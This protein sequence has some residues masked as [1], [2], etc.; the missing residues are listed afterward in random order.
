MEVG[1]AIGN[2]NG[3]GVLGGCYDGSVTLTNTI[4]ANSP[5]GGDCGGG[6]INDGGHNLIEDAP[7][8]SCGLTN[9]VNGNLVG[10]DPLL[11]PLANNG[12]LTETH[13]LCA[14]AGARSPSA[15]PRARPLTPAIRRCAPTRRRT[16]VDQ[17]GF[18]R[19][20]TGHTQCSIGAYEADAT[21]CGGDCDRGGSV[22]IDELLTHG[23]QRPRHRPRFPECRAGDGNQD[24]AI[25]VEEIV[26]AVNDALN[27]CA[28]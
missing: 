17:R 9:G 16:D 14:G 11:G 22:T 8:H 21:A 6:E 25:T 4:V 1:G 23:E 20:G 7:R 27:G 28:A 18:V 13:A 3:C 5:S 15:P 10:V 2:V 24:G 19:P 12:G 26:A